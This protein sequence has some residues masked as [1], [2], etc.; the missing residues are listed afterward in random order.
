MRSRWPGAW[1]H[2]ALPAPRPRCATLCPPWRGLCAASLGSPSPA[3]RHLLPPGAPAARVGRRHDVA[4]GGARG[5][6]AAAR[7]AAAAGGAGGRR[8][9]GSF[10]MIGG[11]G[12][13]SGAHSAHACLRLASE[14]WRAPSACAGA[15]H[16][17]CSRGPPP[18]PS[19]G[20]ACGPTGQPLAH[21]AAARGHAG[22]AAAAGRAGEAGALQGSGCSCAKGTGLTGKWG[23]GWVWVGLRAGAAASCAVWRGLCRSRHRELRAVCVA[24]AQDTAFEASLAD[25]RRR[26]EERAAVEAAEAAAQAE[27][28]AAAVALRALRERCREALEVRLG[29]ATRGLRAARVGRQ[30]DGCL[31]AHGEGPA[32]QLKRQEHRRP[33]HCHFPTPPLTWARRR[34]SHLVALLLTVTVDLIANARSSLLR[35]ACAAS[36]ATRSGGL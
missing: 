8:E 22:G 17:P 25:D 14:R 23:R 2:A 35:L 16:A 31:A 5:G 12:R 13:G 26:A 15:A 18:L 7:V 33:C 6:G 20:A 3:P 34:R 27:R 29:C 10:L 19:P 24:C 30:R 11:G 36:A 1:E 21:A 28:D 9:G 32:R 4:G